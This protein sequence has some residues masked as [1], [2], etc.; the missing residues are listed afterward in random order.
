MADPLAVVAVVLLVEVLVVVEVCICFDLVSLNTR[1]CL[2]GLA[3]AG[4]VVLD[5]RVSIL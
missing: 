3:L 1:F 4:R 5:A 2:G